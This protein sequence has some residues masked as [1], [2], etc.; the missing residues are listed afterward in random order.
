MPGG[1]LSLA[2]FLSGAAGLIFQV[3]WFYRAGLVFGN[4]VWAVTVVLSSFMAGLALG[5]VLAGR[6]AP[7]IARPLLVYAA[8]EAVVALFGIGTTV[9][10]PAISGI[11]TPLGDAAG[12]STLTMNAVRLCA[13]FAVLVVPA[14]AM[15][16]TLPVAVAAASRLATSGGRQP[17][18]PFGRILGHLYG[19][20]T[21]GAVA[22]VIVAEVVL[23]AW[24]GVLGTALSAALL[25]LTAA[26]IAFK[27]SRRPGAQLAIRRTAAATDSTAGLVMSPSARRDAFRPPTDDSRLAT[28][29]S[30]LSTDDSRLETDE[31]RLAT[32]D[33]RPATNSRTRAL[34]AAA[35]VSGASLLAL[36]VVWFR[37]LSMYVLS[38][39]LAMSLM[40]AVVLAAI[41]LGGLFTSAWLVRRRD[42]ADFLPAVALAAGCTVALSY[43]GFQWLT[44]GTQAGEW[45]RVLWFAAALAFPTSFLSG[46][47]FTLTGEA[48]QA[49]VGVPARAAAWLTLANTIGAL[50]GP[51]LAAFLLLPALG[52]EGTF[53]GLAA[54]YAIVALLAASAAGTITGR[55]SSRVTAV[56]LLGVLLTFPF[57]LMRDTYFLRAAETYA[58]DGSEIIATREG[59]SETIFLMQQ[60]WL[61]QGIYDRLVTNGFSM[62][63]T[64]V[65][66][67]RYMRYFAYWPMLF[68]SGPIQRALVIC[69]GVGVTAGAVAHIPSVESIDIAEISPDI[70]AMSDVIYQHGDHPLRDPRVRL[71]VEDGRYFLQHTRERFDLITGEPPPPRTPGAVNIYTREYFQLIHDRLADGGITTYWLPVARPHPGTDVD[72]IIRAFCDVFA[73]CSLWNATPFDLMLAGSRGATGP[74]PEAEFVR[75]WQT[76]GV[77]ARLREVGFEEPEQI[78]AT[79]LGDAAYLQTLTAD[80]PPLTDNFPQRLRPTSRRESLSDPRYGEDGTVAEHYQQVIDPSRAS[81]LFVESAWIRQRLPQP[82]IDR[83]VAWFE[84]QRTINRIFWEGGR[85]LRQIEELHALLTRTRLLTLPLWILGTDEVKQTIAGGADEDGSA[86]DYARGLSALAGRQFP[87]AAAR[88]ADAEARGL[89]SP[90]LRPLRVYALCAAQRIDDARTLARGVQPKDPDEVHFWSWLG[91]QCGVGPFSR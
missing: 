1:L 60:K 48:L 4:S 41:G 74:I 57:G 12:N 32:N 91:P 34:L 10:L 13:A 19:W 37:F 3:V 50:V 35:C 27:L 51:P 45:Y 54:A 75:P 59:L 14:T 7:R 25:D 72:T 87:E 11:L 53:F 90:I 29:D 77:A 30:R 2:F 16:A 22:G 83:S 39:T 44:A 52:M 43:A 17:L 79:F 84:P 33:V 55:L 20:N 9:A 31:P 15:G 5:S 67:M 80:T 58:G 28:D 70:V 89:D 38:T 78:G 26:A 56:A 36:E 65:P 71:H 69:Y 6:L 49:T 8:L 18:M 85:P 73:D 64:A 42:A 46:V 63:G 86:I 47:L 21:L 68:H 66:G 61:G 76:P 62:T 88:F 40:L 82:L 24:V 81:R 23:V